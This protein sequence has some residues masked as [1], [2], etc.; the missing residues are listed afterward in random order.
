VDDSRVL[1]R[2]ERPSPRVPS[3]GLPW[4]RRV[5]ATG[6]LHL[7][8]LTLLVTAVSYRRSPAVATASALPAFSQHDGSAAR[9]VAV[10][11]GVIAPVLIG[12]VQPRY[13]DAA[14]AARIQGAVALQMIV[15]RDGTPDA[16]RIVRSIDPE[17]LD[18]EAM[19][20]VRQWKF[21]PGRI[22]ATPVDAVVTC[23]VDFHIH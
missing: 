2:L 5:A 11:S 6:T 7:I 4:A 10:P 3:T 13:T 20:A 14:L 18:Q 16:L 1:L 21:K 19:A 8:V 17:G 15:R 12:M 22:G 23:I 9:Q